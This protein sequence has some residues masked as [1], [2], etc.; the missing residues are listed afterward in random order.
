[1][2]WPRRSSSRPGVQGAG[3][4]NFASF[5]A[6]D[7]IEFTGDRGKLSLSCYGTEPLALTTAAGVTTIAAETPAH[8]QQPLIQTIV[9]EL[10]GV[11][12]CPSTGESAARTTWV[13]DEVL[14]EYRARM[15]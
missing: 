4:W 11:G 6:A 5:G 13:M 15:R 2:R 14:K 1:M 10:N 8:V 7:V 9:D 3:I 12:I